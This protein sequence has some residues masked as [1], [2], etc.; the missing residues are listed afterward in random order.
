MGP[1]FVRNYQKN[2]TTVINEKIMKIVEKIIG[3]IN[4]KKLSLNEIDEK[5]FKLTFV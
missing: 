2:L 5:L 4:V 3:Y 1:D